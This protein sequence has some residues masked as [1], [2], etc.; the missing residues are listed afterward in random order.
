MLEKLRPAFK[1]AIEPIAKALVRMGLTADM[2]T[3][4]GAI[5]TTLVGIA[6]G[7]TGWLFWGAVA[8][9]VLVMF[10]SLDGSVAQ[11]TTGGTKYGAFLDSSLDRIADWG[12]LMG[13]AIYFGRE[14]L[15]ASRPHPA[16]TTDT[17]LIIGLACT[18][19]AMMTS[20]V[21]PYVR[22]RAESVGYE[23]KGGIA[24]RSDRLTI[25]IIGLAIT[26]LANLPLVLVIDMA[27]L[28]VFGTITVFQRLFEVKAAM[29]RDE[30]IY[31]IEYTRLGRD[32]SLAAAAHDA[33]EPDRR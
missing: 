21:T 4:I 8:L 27:L 11:L 17:V 1:R 2:I 12:V 33:D 6:T 25:I 30:A 24:T 23:A 28:C 32:G 16:T 31:G 20:F 7:I 14:F 26:G 15:S 22:A 18:L 29:Q 19:Y 3:I 13:V 10:D 9:T 5:G